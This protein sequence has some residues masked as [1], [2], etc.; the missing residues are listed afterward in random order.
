[1]TEIKLT[2]TYTEE[3]IA[4]ST[5]KYMLQSPRIKFGFIIS[6]PYFALFIYI[7]WKYLQYT[8]NYIPYMLLFIGFVLLCGVIIFQ[9]VIY[10]K[11]FYRQNSE[12][13]EE[14][15]MI[16]S[17]KGIDS[18]IKNYKEIKYEWNH[19][20]KVGE[21]EKYYFLYHAKLKN[22]LYLIIP[23]RVVENTAQE[24]ALRSLLQDKIP[25]HTGKK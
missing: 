16:L 21:D 25:K 1:M 19:F 3:E 13:Q 12:Y 18:I 4:E 24:E 11:R 2:F 23:K 9:I 14:R 6:I 5:R 8:Q 7:T 10:P 20:N 22:T 17:E 15:T